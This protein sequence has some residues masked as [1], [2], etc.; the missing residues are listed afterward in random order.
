M[1]D[2][3]KKLMGIMIDAQNIS[4]SGSI[5][6][7][8]LSGIRIGELRSGVYSP[9]FSKVIGIAMIDKSYCKVS[10]ECQ[11]VINEDICKGK[12]CKLPFI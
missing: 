6:I 8:D 1:H 2:K 12:L 5:E 10:Q 11:I 7:K 4:V 9:N 3:I